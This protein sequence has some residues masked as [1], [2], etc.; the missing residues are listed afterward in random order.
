MF[1]CLP[2]MDV[3]FPKFSGRYNQESDTSEESLS[4]FLFKSRYPASGDRADNGCVNGS[5]V[6]NAGRC[7]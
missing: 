4:L 3:N 7:T 2:F 6:F 1:Q 5:C